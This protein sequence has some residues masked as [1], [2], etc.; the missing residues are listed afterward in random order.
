MG[1]ENASTPDEQ[2]RRITRIAAAKAAKEAVNA[3]RILSKANIIKPTRRSSRL[4]AQHGSPLGTPSIEAGNAIPDA[5]H[6]GTSVRD[7]LSLIDLN[8]SLD[9]LKSLLEDLEADEEPLPR[10]PPTPSGDPLARPPLPEPTST[11]HKF[12][13][14]DETWAK[15]LHGGMWSVMLKR[16]GS[17]DLGKESWMGELDKAGCGDKT[18]LPTPAF[19]NLSNDVHPIFA[20]QNWPMEDFSKHPA[21]WEALKPAL[22][23]ASNLLLSPAGL[24]FFRRVRYG[25]EKFDPESKRTYFDYTEDDAKTNERNKQVR[26]EL[27]QLAPHITLLFGVTKT[28]GKPGHETQTHAEHCLSQSEFGTQQ[29]FRGDY[30]KLPTEASSARYIIIN[31][32]YKDYAASGKHGPCE[33][34]RL[35]FSLG[36]SIHHEIAHAYY[37]RDR[38][39]KQENYSEP[40]WNLR[41]YNKDSP[42]G[43]D[44]EL[45]YALEHH[46]FNAS[47]RTVIHPQDG[48]DMEWDR[49]LI[50]MHGNNVVSVPSLLTFPVDPKWIHKLLTQK[51]WDR[52]TTLKGQAAEEALFVPQ[53][54]WAGLHQ[55]THQHEGKMQWTRRCERRPG[56]RRKACEVEEWEEKDQARLKEALGDAVRKRFLEAEDDSELSEE[57]G[58]LRDGPCR[59][60]KKL[61]RPLSTG[62][63]APTE[64][65]A[66]KGGLRRNVRTTKASCLPSV[67]QK[68]EQD[69][70]R[71]KA[72]GPK[73]IGS[74]ETQSEKKKKRRR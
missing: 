25:V 51:F 12:D 72:F 17:K 69:C 64:P 62:G 10:G 2:P 32:A 47:I 21:L 43:E 31:Q 22:Q 9:T 23:L 45:G 74:R 13:L 24:S 49:L 73:E 63:L 7:C 15:Y 61:K 26:K 4:A 1:H 46:V 28:R 44:G 14:D 52:L 8:P 42:N 29:F 57:D 39:D 40:F 70:R 54:Q 6:T 11:R 30:S 68:G 38:T 35:A 41:Q 55:V 50:A 53:A 56:M 60:G 37:V 48:V 19:G 16:K 27:E 34:A 20:P 3:A 71:A 59:P 36:Y 67:R 65:A 66:S 5:R 33:M 58:E 18:L